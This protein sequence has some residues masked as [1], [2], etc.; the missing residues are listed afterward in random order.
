MYIVDVAPLARGISRESLSYFSLKPAQPGSL[1]RIPLRKKTVSGIVL[2]CVNAEER[3]QE[4]RN[5]TF[6][7]KKVSDLKEQSFF[8]KEFL[9]AV[10]RTAFESIATTG[11]TLFSLA[12]NELLESL[13]EL[14]GK[15]KIPT[16]AD[17]GKKRKTEAVHEKY[18]VQADEEERYAHYKSLIREQFAR[19]N[20]LFFCFPSIQELEAALKKLEKGVEQYTYVFHSGLTP[21]VILEK[22][23][24][25]LNEKHPVLILGT[26]PFLAL[27]RSDIG[28]VVIE[29]HFSR[30]YKTI[31]RPFLDLRTFAE[32]YAKELCAK[33]ILGDIFLGTETIFHYQ[34]GEYIDLYPPKFRSLSSAQF[35]V[36]DMRGAKTVG[37]ELP[38]LSPELQAIIRQTIDEGKRL[39]LFCARKGLSPMTVCSDCGTMVRCKH[40]GSGVVLHSSMKGNFFLCHTCGERRGTEERCTA[41]ESWKLVPLGI[42]IDRVKDEIE[43]QF[44]EVHLS[45]LERDAVKTHKKAKDVAE[46]FFKTPGSILLGTEMALPYLDQKVEFTGVVSMDSF[47][48]IPDYRILE[49]IMDILLIVRGET[50]V[51]SLVKTRRP[52]ELV[53]EF[54]LKGNMI[55]FYREETAIR[56]QFGYPPFSTVVKIS[57]EGEKEVIAEKMAEAQKI[58][59]PEYVMEVFPS[60]VR[61]QKGKSVLHAIIKIP[62]NPK[63]KW[64]D[65][66]FINRALSLSPEFEI[67]VDPESLL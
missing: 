20:S 55:D 22:T 6:E 49:K 3:K 26:V 15:E 47:F 67:R 36:L 21:K 24:A 53:F 62:E 48:S 59:D 30:G 54:G 1:V 61:G 19:K 41:C 35:S 13:E 60:F 18:I 42:G 27:P 56:N 44:P 40:C 5:A 4:I 11:S 52:E 7:M 65:E 45:V 23:E 33:L 16:T 38:V 29:R 50:V 64:P 34:E 2:E 28:G 12:P 8:L 39:F 17:T 66:A 10:K 31:S 57:L 51:R 63:S 9:T 46:A 58:F 14:Q 32:N 37:G 43:K 25:V